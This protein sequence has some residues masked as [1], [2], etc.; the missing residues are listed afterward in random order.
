MVRLSLGPWCA[1]LLSILIVGSA[2]PGQAATIARLPS[3]LVVEGHMST[4][5]S[6]VVEYLGVRYAEPPVGRLRFAPPKPYEGKGRIVASKFV[7]K[8]I[9]AT[10]KSADNNLQ[11]PYVHIFSE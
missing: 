3:G 6:S 7:S 8:E 1:V 10:N 5:K 2:S 11:A 9:K 4:W